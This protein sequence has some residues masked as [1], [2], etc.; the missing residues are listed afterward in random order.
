MPNA[1]EIKRGMIL[2]IEGE[3]FAVTEA[4]HITPGNWRGMVQATMKNIKTGSKL[5]RR[6]RSTETVETAFLDMK[7]VQYSYKDPAGYAFYDPQ[8]YETIILTEDQVGDAVRYLRENDEAKITFHDGQ[9]I[10]IDL[11]SSVVLTVT[12]TDPGV[13]G[14]TVSNVFKPA[15]VETGIVVK[16]PLFIEQGEKIRVDTRTGE[17]LGRAN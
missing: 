17:F 3:L 2:V 11:P 10:G 16:V 13:R 4:Q 7:T 14:D 5:Q 8:S 15:K 6:F 12:E 1:T 9:P